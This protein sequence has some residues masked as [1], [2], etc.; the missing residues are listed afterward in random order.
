[1][2]PVPKSNTL[3]GSGTV[4]AGDDPDAGA[5]DVRTIGSPVRKMLAW[6]GTLVVMVKNQVPN[7][8]GELKNRL[9]SPLR[10]SGVPH[11]LPVVGCPTSC[12][13]MSN[14]TPPVHQY[15][16]AKS[17]W[18]KVPLPVLPLTV[19]V[20]LVMSLE[21]STVPAL[22]LGRVVRSS[23]MRPVAVAVLPNEAPDHAREYVCKTSAK[24]APVASSSPA[25]S[26]AFN[27]ID[28]VLS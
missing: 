24:A 22:G 21:I 10:A 13:D 19:T 9:K 4:E 27:F 6:G 12:V 3:P 7:G 26:S 14:V 11:G 5:N 16:K 25:R 15:V 28:V 23:V 8:P 1:V 20:R 2:I 17:A 18:V